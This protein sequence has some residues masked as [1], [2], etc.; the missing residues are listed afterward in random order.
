MS[1]NVAYRSQVWSPDRNRPTATAEP[2]A[3]APQRFPAT[4]E[5]ATEDHFESTTHLRQLVTSAHAATSPLAVAYEADVHFA[6]TYYLA[7]SAGFRDPIARAIAEGTQKPDRDY[8]SPVPLGKE[9]LKNGALLAALPPTAAGPRARL[10]ARQEVIRTLM[11]E[12]HFLDDPNSKVIRPGNATALAK[13]QRAMSED[14]RTF[15]ESLHPYQDTWSHQ[16][17]PSLLSIGLPGG[18]PGNPFS[19]DCDQTHNHPEIALE[20]AE[21]TY[22]RLQEYAAL[23]PAYVTEEPASFEDIR[24][25]LEKFIAAETETEKLAVATTEMGLDLHEATQNF[26]KHDMSLDH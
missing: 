4:T 16:G 24:P 10:L 17:E 2:P 22:E 13:V 23:H 19:H 7:R 8:R 25:T 9:Y 14:P 1:I 21:A 3:E 12:W 15:G 6:E 5:P 11:R 26:M 18:H 20:A